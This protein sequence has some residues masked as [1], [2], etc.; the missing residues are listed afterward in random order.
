LIDLQ[1]LPALFATI[2]ALNVILVLLQF[3]DPLLAI[4][5]PKSGEHP[6][7][8]ALRPPFA[9]IV[10]GSAFWLVGGSALRSILLTLFGLMLIY[11]AF[12]VIAA[13]FLFRKI[14]GYAAKRRA[15]REVD[16]VIQ[17]PLNRLLFASGLGRMFYSLRHFSSGLQRHHGRICSRRQEAEKVYR[18]VKIDELGLVLRRERVGP[19]SLGD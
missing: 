11:L 6:L 18:I 10:A 19:L 15:S 5:T 13:L 2:V 4:L 7:A 16:S 17:Q 14:P 8:T 12:N 9:L 1:L 3:G